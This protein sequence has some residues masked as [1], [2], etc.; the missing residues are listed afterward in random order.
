MAVRALQ[1]LHLHRNVAAHVRRRRQQH[2][3]W[4]T[5]AKQVHGRHL[6]AKTP[7]HLMREHAALEALQ[8]HRPV[9]LHAT[10]AEVGTPLQEKQPRIRNADATPSSSSA[11]EKNASHNRLHGPQGQLHPAGKGVIRPGAEPRAGPRRAT[12]SRAI[13]R[14]IAAGADLLRRGAS[15]RSS[16]KA[17]LLQGARHEHRLRVVT[18]ALQARQLLHQLSCDPG[19]RV[20]TGAAAGTQRRCDQDQQRPEPPYWVPTAF[21]A[22]LACLAAFF[23]RFLSDLDLGP[24]SPSPEESSE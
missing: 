8:L 9:L 19:F 15:Q 6:Q 18:V 5:H 1:A 7:L 20:I 12:E 4:Q 13:S 3:S 11:P 22:C 17:G 14:G 2:A 16:S 23:C 24:P 21:A 10:A